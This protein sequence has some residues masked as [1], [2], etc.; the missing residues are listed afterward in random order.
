MVRTIREAPQIHR[1]ACHNEYLADKV[2][3]GAHV[4]FDQEV[5]DRVEQQAENFAKLALA[6]KEVGDE[7]QDLEKVL[8]R[9]NSLS[10]VDKETAK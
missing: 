5:Q 10:I 2:G 1:H 6:Y 3:G 8:W 4:K 9:V 7:G